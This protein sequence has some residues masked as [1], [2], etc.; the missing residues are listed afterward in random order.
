[1]RGQLLADPAAVSTRMDEGGRATPPPPMVPKKF[2][3]YTSCKVLAEFVGTY[4]LVFVIGCNVLTNS[5]GSAL[6]IG[7]MLM[8][9]IYAL[10]SVSGAHF[11]PAVTIAIF[12]SQRGLLNFQDACLY[13]LGQLCG[14]FAAALTYF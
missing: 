7:G 10:G 2:V 11:N 9:M 5:I 14:G 3:H 1:M 4:Y 6:S 12:G 8:V 13:I